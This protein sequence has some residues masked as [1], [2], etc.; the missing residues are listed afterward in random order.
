MN[1]ETVNVDVSIAGKAIEEIKATEARTGDSAVPTVS[2]W[3]TKKPILNYDV[4]E[5]RVE[6]MKAEVGATKQNYEQK[7]KRNADDE[8]R[9]CSAT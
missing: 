4:G 9:S 3:E 1:P 8:D 5:A 7:T 2:I 6:D